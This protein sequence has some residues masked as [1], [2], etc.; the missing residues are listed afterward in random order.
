MTISEAVNVA[1]LQG[2]KWLAHLR[3]EETTIAVLV[4][5]RRT[6]CFDEDGCHEWHPTEDLLASD[7]WEPVAGP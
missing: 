1:K 5:E 4:H 6:W 7:G 3:D 2:W